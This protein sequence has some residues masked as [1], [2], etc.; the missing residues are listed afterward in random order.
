MN[1][2]KKAKNNF[3]GKLVLV[4][5][6]SF[7]YFDALAQS[8]EGYPLKPITLLIGFSGVSDIFARAI[9][10]KLQERL[11][12]PVVVELKPGASGVISTSALSKAKP[13]GYTIGI[14][15]SNH[16]TNPFL[17]QLPYDTMKSF[18]P[19]SMLGRVP[20]ALTIS[21]RANGAVSSATSLE[22]FVTQARQSVPGVSFAS[23]G[24]GGMTHLTGELFK[25]IFKIDMVHIPYK[26]GAPALND[27]LGGQVQIQFP[28]TAL[29]SRFHQNK[30]ERLRVL[31]VAS[32]VRVS[33]MPDV[34]TFKELGF[35]ELVVS[36]WYALMA[37]AGTPSQ[38]INKLSQAVIEVMKHPEVQS[39]VPGMVTAG[40]R[41][42]EV[43]TFLKTEMQRWSKLIIDSNIKME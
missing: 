14:V 32:E 43:D 34:P 21:T 3:F 19:I 11:G 17:Q 26:G 13:D 40:S 12:Q 7:I 22:E 28:T 2:I 36:E 42:E 29:I 16:A 33:S 35:G 41:P 9:G 31:A 6:S 8:S 15:I 27:L 23:A 20:I 24:T 18:A 38:I 4:I 10:M 37:P 25:N 39:K 30:D 5:F 1:F